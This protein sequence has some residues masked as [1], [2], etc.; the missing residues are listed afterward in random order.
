MNRKLKNRLPW[1][2][3]NML[4][5]S[6]ALVILFILGTGWSAMGQITIQGS[7][8]D[9]DQEPLIGVN[10]QVK[11]EGSGTSTDFD[12]RFILE[13]INEQ[14]TLIFS[15]IGYQ[16]LEIEVDGRTT[17]DVV[18]LTDAQTLDEVVVTALG[19]RKESKAL[20]Y[21]VT[22]LEGE[23][24]TK[25]R[26]NNFANSLTGLVA[27]VNVSGV[28][29]GPG[30]SSRV[31]I[32]GNTSIAGDNQPL[33]IINGLPMDNTQFGIGEGENP[34]WG[35]NI[36][37]INPDDIQEIT[38]LKGATAAAL[39]G[40][41]AKNGAIIITTKSGRSQKG[42]GI[43]FNS[44]LTTEVPY[45]LW[46]LQD[47][48]G[49]GYGN[50]RPASVQD[51][52]NHGQ[53]HWGEPYDGVPTI[54]FDGVERPYS[55]VKDQ[56]LDDF[57]SNGHS[58]HSN[59]SFSEGGDKGTFR[60]GL[61]DMRNQ[62]IISNSN[63]NRNNISLGINQSV[64]D[65]ITIS[66][67]ADYITENVN[68]RYVIG[69]RS[70][71]A[72]TIL[73]VNSNMPTSSLAPGYD[74]NFHEKTLG[75]DFN[76]TNPYFVVNRMRNETSKDRFIT[77]VN[78]TWNL[79]D[80]LFVRG[81]AGQDYYTFKANNIRPDGTAFRQNGQ[82]DETGMNFWERNFELLLGMDKA[83]NS[84][85]NLSVNLGG[86]M[87]SQYR[88]TTN[89][90][91]LGFVIPQLHVVNNTSNQNTETQVYNR[92]INSI[93]A[94]SE[95]GYKN[96]LYLNLTGRNDWFSTLNPESN[97]YFYPSAGISFVFSEVLNLPNAFDFGKFRVAYAAVGGDTD[98]Y[99][100]NLTYGLLNYT[101]GNYSLGT[102]NQT[103]VP[104]SSLRPLSVNEFE[105]GFDMRFFGNR[106]GVDMA[107]YNK[108]TTNDI[109]IETITRTSGYSGVSVNVGK[110]RNR[111]AEL[112]LRGT[113][114]QKSDFSWDVSANMSYNKNVVLKI[115]DNTNELVLA[116][117]RAAIKLIEGME[118]AQIVGRTILR[119]EQGQDIIDETGLPIVPNDIVTFGSGIHKWTGGLM[120][121]LQYKSLSL[122][123]LIDGKFGAK[124]YSE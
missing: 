17:I 5:Q 75:T 61:S 57:Y 58:L 118:Y 80:W 110:L 43:E 60:V 107:V 32:R 29:S 120:N 92:R 87:M 123:F 2:T 26:E 71:G 36:S 96:F 13:D 106:L 62:G 40:S 99:R 114:I 31:T 45:Y 52:A 8:T 55:Y 20:G 48:Y 67:H 22:K 66:A 42:L 59:V 90:T 91:G 47:E 108:L 68:N 53:N 117:G 15:Y 12:G 115:S 6:L 121:R 64:T 113:P 1:T 119:N 69:G 104:N 14:A 39:Y 103:I 79:T 28:G 23:Q 112:L 44:S 41:R 50:R 89:I 73:Y 72:A 122:S 94:T 33:Y 16:T 54:Q 102:I 111:G 19:I 38:V 18:L 109:A 86:N 84:D 49:Q 35:D 77:S 56:V 105:A 37:S 21:S 9:E 93:F 10:V 101:Y 3:R 70:N 124:I 34:D 88:Y 46:E 24:F 74:E 100:L 81:K 97:N 76:A 51:A 4:P 85:F 27:G 95:L 83:L 11:G 116:D 25:V 82:I 98:P 78:A 30:G 65:R 7:V 63:M